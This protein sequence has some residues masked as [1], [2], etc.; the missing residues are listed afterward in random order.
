MRNIEY[1]K[2]LADD[3]LNQQYGLNQN[4]VQ[5][6]LFSILDD[7]VY[8]CDQDGKEIY[9]NEA[10][11]SMLDQEKGV[12]FD[13]GVL[14]LQGQN[15]GNSITNLIKFGIKYVLLSGKEEFIEYQKSVE[16]GLYQ[17]LLIRIR[18][19]LDENVE[20][21]FV[22]VH[23]VDITQK[24]KSEVERIENEVLLQRA[25]K[26]AGI[27]NFIYYFRSRTWSCSVGFEQ[28]FNVDKNYPKTRASF[29][30]LLNDEWRQQ[31][32]QYLDQDNWEEIRFDH[33]YCTKG[34]KDAIERWIHGIGEVILDEK[35]IPVK[36]IGT[37]Q[38]INRQIDHERE[39][40]SLSYRDKLTNLYSRRFYED[41]LRRLDKKENLPLTIVVGDVNDLKLTNETYGHEKGDELLKKAANAIVE[42]CRSEDIV[43]RWGGDE[44]VI[45]LPKTD[46][47]VAEKIV[48]R[49][50]R[51]CMS[52]QVNSLQV[53]VSF[54]WGT[55]A[56][57]Y[58]DINLV[59]KNAEKHMYSNKVKESMGFKKDNIMSLVTSLDEKI[60]NKSEHA[61]RVGNLCQKIGLALGYSKHDCDLLKLVGFLHDVGEIALDETVL[62]K[63]GLFNEVDM[64]EVQRH[65]E[66]GYRIIKSFYGLSDLAEYVLCHHEKWDGSGY[67]NGLKDQAIPAIARIVAIADSYDAMTNNRSYKAVLS[68]DEAIMEIKRNVGKQFDPEIARVFVEKVLKRSW[69]NSKGNHTL[70]EF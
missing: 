11:S 51:N 38:D 61:H 53:H 1:I 63:K 12:F 25:Q 59:F 40:A 66:T 10:F 16:T 48:E 21:Q 65:P 29:Y 5:Q 28:I 32:D 17:Y 23:A 7:P 47:D 19:V 4:E 49:I 26:N 6:V 52:E 33:I 27:C 50:K 67:P 41:S 36:M 2:H 35:G 22:L 57:E 42:A 9:V 18:P 15:E 3:L 44:F 56:S 55:K 54:G 8:F 30:Y 69:D 24:R 39:I 14:S 20:V 64:K 70:Y 58:E 43:S 31:L 45:L 46:S 68:Q 60:P 62:N 37:F 13:S 34:I